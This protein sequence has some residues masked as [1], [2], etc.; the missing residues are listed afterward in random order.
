MSEEVTISE[1]LDNSY[2]EYARY[3]L[4]ER[5]IPS[6]TDGLKPVQRR[7]LYVAKSK[8]KSKPVKVNTLSGACMHLHPHG[9]QSLNSSISLMAQEFAG[10]NN[11]AMLEG[12]GAFGGRVTGKGI[13]SV[14]APRYV[15][16]KVS[17]VFDK[18]LCK[19]YEIVDLVPNYDKADE[20]LKTFLP[21]FPTIFLNPI[22]GIGVGFACE[23][24]PY[25]PLE[26]IDNQIRVLKGQKQ[27]EILPWYREFGG[28]VVKKDGRPVCRGA[29]EWERKKTQIRIT[30]LPATEN[31]EGY[32]DR[33]EKLIDKDE[34]VK[35][36]ED[37]TGD[38][39]DILV[40]L[41]RNN[42]YYMHPEETFDGLYLEENVCENLTLLDQN[43]NLKVYDSVLDVIEDFTK[44]RLGKYVDRY[45]KKLEDIEN[46]I[47]K[48]SEYLRVVNAGF[49]DN[50]SGNS[51]EKLRSF[52]EDLGVEN[53]TRFL[54]MSVGSFSLDK[55]KDKEERKKELEKEQKRCGKILNS[56]DE[57]KDIYIDELKELK[58]W[59][60]KKI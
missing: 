57:R 27:K 4:Q 48:I 42:P 32:I 56:E 6:L 26:I 40:Y 10:A 37:R 33:L 41:R 20:E 31:R 19:D 15:R 24:Y 2:R 30:E 59:F 49:P 9:D 51:T 12:H 38:R 28:E 52:L 22:S 34:W 17:D 29:Y 5:V 45:E 44:W 18:L 16:V 35:K 8:A 46:E 23:I 7:I 58:G 21:I 53:P 3:T 36:Y 54:R 25:N 13:D 55:A 47:D 14:G 60:K 50:V 11:F 1:Q 43:G 39:F